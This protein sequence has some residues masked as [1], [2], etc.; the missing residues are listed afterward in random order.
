M[1]TEREQNIRVEG[2][3]RQGYSLKKKRDFLSLVAS[4]AMDRTSDS[5]GKEMSSPWALSVV[6]AV[7]GHLALEIGSACLEAICKTNLSPFSEVVR[8]SQIYLDAFLW[9]FFKISS[10]YFPLL[11]II[12]TFIIVILCLR[13]KP[14]NVPN[15]F[16]VVCLICLA[17]SQYITT[18]SRC[19]SVHNHSVSL[20]L[21]T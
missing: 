10:Y 5:L 14:S 6:P 7:N 17:V 19:V 21:S 12:L 20:C 18:L 16:C 13:Y 11:S 4:T 3:Q 8:T 2:N 15:Y 1:W 9:H